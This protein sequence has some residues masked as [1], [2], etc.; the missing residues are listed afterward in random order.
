MSIKLEPKEFQ[1][2]YNEVVVVAESDNTGKSKFSYINE[3][4]VNGNLI[5]TLK[6]HANPQGFGVMNIS[7]H[8]ESYVNSDINLNDDNAFKQIPNSFIKYSVAQK[9]EYLASLRFSSVPNVGGFASY[10]AISSTHL[11]QV[12]DYVIITL[13]VNNFPNTIAAYNGLQL[14][15]AVPNN[16]TI[17]TDKPFFATGATGGVKLAV[18][19]TSVLAGEFN[20]ASDKFALN[21]VIDWV[22]VPSWDPNTHI[23]DTTSLGKFFTNLENDQTVKLDDRITF[24]FY[25]KTSG[26]ATYLEVVSTLGTIR[27]LNNFA[28][29]SDANK[30]LSVGVAPSDILN[31]S[32]S[33]IATIS[34]SSTVIDGNISSYTVKLLNA[35]F[36]PT[37][38]TFSFKV[39]DECKAYENYKLVYLNR[40]GSFSNFNFEL[41]SS[42][43]NRV[44]KKEYSKGYGSYTYSEVDNINEFSWN[45]QDRGV[46]T[47]ATSES[48]TITVT[49]DYMTET[50]GNKF[51][52]LVRS[53]EVYHLSNTGVL[54]SVSLAASSA[55]MKTR[56]I[57]KLINHTLSFNYSTKNTTQR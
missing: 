51:W 7:K 49:S 18:G 30:F 43:V 17:V 9:E 29:T 10:Q 22:D 14:I 11:F 1:S 26:D 38:E 56:L 20:F 42:K 21:N 25:N 35:A 48:E 37:S 15:T 50:E 47:Y 19:S 8:L 3:I 31:H 16:T 34:G 55:K 53:P 45:S 33:V 6:V 36:E 23:L 46:T 12:G 54:R 44:R 32:G 2:V 52:D 28:T 5:N 40:G 4:S 39:K 57:D 24:N 41:A 27:I 13:D